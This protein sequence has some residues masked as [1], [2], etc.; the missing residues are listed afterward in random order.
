[1]I[2]EVRD[3]VVT[4][5]GRVNKTVARIKSEI[6]PDLKR[7]V[8]ATRIMRMNRPIPIMPQT[9]V[10]QGDIVR[11]IGLPEA[12]DKLADELGRSIEPSE[13][14]DYIYL[15][16]GIIAGIL[17][18]G[19]SIPI[20]GSPVSLGIGGGCLL[21]GLLFGWIQSRHPAIGNLPSATALHLRDFGLAVFIACVGLAAGPQAFDVIREKGIMLPLFAIIVVLVPMISSMLYARY[22]VKMNPILITGALAG[23]LTCTAA[24][25]AAVDEADSETPVLGYTVPYAIANVLLTLLG[26]VIV[27]LV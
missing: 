22:V 20:A 15:A 2:G 8:Y 24:L 5:E 17:I 9:T 1:L 18:G 6:S 16:L 7:G 13:A 3:V 26:P 12:V 11:L 19:I 4:H 14:V 25:N 10:R 23:L 27:L 21:S